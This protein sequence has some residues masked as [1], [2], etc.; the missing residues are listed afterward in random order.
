MVSKFL[1]GI[2]SQWY[3]CIC[4]SKV[5]EKV[6]FKQLYEFFQANKLFYN[7]QNGFRTKHST[8]F[9]ALEV[10][11]RIMVEMDKN[12]IPIN[13]YLDLSK[14]FDTLDHSILIDKT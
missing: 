14:A 5:F 6:I 3:L 11:D 4:I 9:A 2:L 7:S 12:D 13:I 1:I 10:I 8:E